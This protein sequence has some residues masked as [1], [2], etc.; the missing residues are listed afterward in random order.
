MKYR[1]PRKGHWLG[2]SAVLAAL[3][4]AVAMGP[5]T[6]Q[7]TE[8]EAGAVAGVN[9]SHLTAP[10][11]PQGELTFLWGS[12]FT[13][14]G[15]LIGATASTGLSEVGGYQLRLSGDFLYGYHRGSGFAEHEEQGSRIDVHFSTHVIRL[16]VIARLGASPQSSGPTV[17]LG[18]E[19]IIGM[20]SGA[21]VVTT[22]VEE[23]IEPVETTPT[24]SMAGVFAL[25]Y[26]VRRDDMT[27]PF[28]ARVSWNPFVS[29]STEGRMKGLDSADEPNEFR[30]A[31]DWQFM[32]TAGVRWAM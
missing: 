23:S 18:L 1:V 20:M 12:A 28:D 7:A 13:G 6:A 11:D 10:S 8:L 24:T 15:T 32:F 17:G 5:S 16:P 3:S 19:P 2:V 9:W 31:F 14:T 26:E 4:F 25:G 27:I 21:E 22:N 30:M 29:S